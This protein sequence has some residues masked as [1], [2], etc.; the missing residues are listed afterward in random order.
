M[1]QTDLSDALLAWVHS[2][3][4]LVFAEV[5]T[6]GGEK[7]VGGGGR[8]KIKVERSIGTNSDSCRHRNACDHVG[9]AGIELL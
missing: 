9:C 5:N 1:L 7:K 6:G 8:T 2:S 4:E 3:S